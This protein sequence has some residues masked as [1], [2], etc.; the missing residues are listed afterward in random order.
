MPHFFI[1]PKNI[2]QSSFVIEGAEAHH[3]TNVRRVKKGDEIRLFDGTGKSYLVCI[4]NVDK[5]KVSGRIIKEEELKPTRI[6]L[7]VYQSVPKGERFDWLVEK[8]T[9]IGVSKLFPLITERSVVKKVPESKQK[10]WERLS[11][12]SSQQCLRQDIMEISTPIEFNAAVKNISSDAFNIIPWEGASN[13]NKGWEPLYGALSSKA[14]VT[15]LT[16]ANIFIGPE[17]GF[18]MDEIK[19]AE[20]SGIIPVSLGQ[21]ILRVETAGLVSAILVLNGF[22]EFISK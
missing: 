22:G 9:E 2:K 15:K 14:E 18:T 16:Q 20:K 17:G 12:S 7:N 21:R 1:P 13:I 5:L 6:K 19:L 4:E 11:L 8:F 10:R 3:L